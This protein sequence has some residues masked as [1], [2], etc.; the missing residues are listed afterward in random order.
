MADRQPEPG[1][2]GDRRVHQ[3]RAERH[4]RP[5]AAILDLDRD[6]VV[7]T[8]GGQQRQRLVEVGGHAG[9]DVERCPCLA[10][11]C[12]G[13]VAAGDRGHHRR[14]LRPAV[15][16]PLDPDDLPGQSADG[17]APAGGV[18]ARVGGQ[19]GQVHRP[20][21]G[22]LPR[23]N[24]VAVLAGALEHQGGGAVAP[25]LGDG[26]GS[27]PRLLV[28]ADQQAQLPERPRPPGEPLHRHHGQHQA[29]LHVGHARAVAAVALAAERPLGH[30]AERE[31]RVG[32]SEQR[33][34]GLPVAGQR[35]HHA[36]GRAVRFLDPRRRHAQRFQPA[37][38]HLRDLLLLRA[39]GRRVDVDQLLQA[40]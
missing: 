11:Q 21:Q 28:G 31:H 1:R 24:Q 3:P 27:Q 40:A 8:A 33:H 10:R 15:G 35:Q 7:G 30:G 20:P 2:D 22:A 38:D 9:A 34:R 32:M 6:A 23:R 37:G 14:H 17:A 39:V 26:G 12:V 5:G 25:I 29:A 16:Q 36:A 19:A 4:R 13:G 18:R